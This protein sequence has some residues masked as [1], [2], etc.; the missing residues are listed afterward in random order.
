MG[1]DDPDVTE[2]VDDPS[3]SDPAVVSDPHFTGVAAR[4]AFDEIGGGGYT[5]RRVPVEDTGGGGTRLVHWRETV[6]DNEL[7]TGFIDPVSNPLSLVTI[8]SLEDM[9]YE[10]DRSVSEFYQLSL[11][12][13]QAANRIYLG[14][15]V[16]REPIFT[17][18]S[19]GRIRPLTAR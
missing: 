1:L 16:L 19:S 6:F 17:I 12:V 5:G 15:D 9:G 13:S 8:A 7:M 18:D 4:T 14:D 11:S 2:W 10:V 3:R